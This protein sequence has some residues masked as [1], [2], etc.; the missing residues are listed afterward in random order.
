MQIDGKCKDCDK[1]VLYLTK[2]DREH[3]VVFTN[4]EYCH[5]HYQQHY[6]ELLKKAIASKKKGTLDQYGI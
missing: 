2:Y 4:K 5:E 3:D 1:K 6:P